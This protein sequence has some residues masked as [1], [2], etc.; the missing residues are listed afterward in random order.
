MVA[1]QLVAANV[2]API[3]CSE[4]HLGQFT[5]YGPTVC[6]D[7]ARITN[8]RRQICEFPTQKIILRQDQV[9][10]VIDTIFSGWAARYCLLPDGQ[11]QILSFLV[12]GDLMCSRPYSAGRFRS[13][14]T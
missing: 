11:R 14:I 4:C 2:K 13:L 10:N 6:A 5:P 9:S 7:P 3:S 12:P 8:L 1:I